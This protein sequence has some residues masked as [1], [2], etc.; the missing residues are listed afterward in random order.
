MFH[1]F[2]C[3]SV[4]IISI[5]SQV[6]QVDSKNTHAQYDDT[7]IYLTSAQKGQLARF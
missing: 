6:F 4:Q 5:I 2:V 3:T 7:R 1:G